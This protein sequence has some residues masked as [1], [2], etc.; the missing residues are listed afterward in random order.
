M[1]IYL[2]NFTRFRWVD[3]RRSR[4]GNAVSAMII[5][6]TRAGALELGQ[7]LDVA[8]VERVIN[9]V[10]A[11]R[12]LSRRLDK[13]FVEEH[14]RSWTTPVADKKVIYVARESMCFLDRVVWLHY[15]R[16]VKQGRKRERDR[17]RDRKKDEHGREDDKKGKIKTQ[18]W[19]E[20]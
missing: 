2:M 6:H 4:E 19:R 14:Q 5:A 12:L 16:T 15:T 20:K 18:E 8:P 1:S 7:S 9:R 17:D 3:C 10:Y 11:T 13:M